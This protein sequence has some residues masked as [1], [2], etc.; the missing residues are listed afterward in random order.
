MGF[1]DCK[2]QVFMW[3]NK[4]LKIEGQPLCLNF[5]QKMH[6]NKRIQKKKKNQNYKYVEIEVR[7]DFPQKTKFTHIWG[8]YKWPYK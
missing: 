6:I 7:K 4:G 1:M 2:I 8:G 5:E 3:K